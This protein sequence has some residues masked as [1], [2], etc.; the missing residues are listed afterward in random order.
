MLEYAVRPFATPNSF[1][2]I[3]IPST[4]SAGNQRATITWGSKTT[5]APTPSLSN[6]FSV[7]CC[8]EELTEVD[9]EG[10]HVQI[11]IT[12]P[13]GDEPHVTVFRSNKL[14]LHKPKNNPCDSPL[15]QAL[16]Q[17]FGLDDSGDV[18][19]DLGFAGTETLQQQCGAIWHLDNNT[20]AGA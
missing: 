8:T 2:K 11:P 15:D 18:T 7:I 17:S 16:G 20:A 9:R 1:G 4:P 12:D 3:I 6:N 14:R 19:I 13:E 10:E 5:N